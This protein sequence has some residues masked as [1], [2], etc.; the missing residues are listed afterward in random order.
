M[1]DIQDYIEYTIK[2]QESVTEIPP[3]HVYIYRINSRS[4]FKAKDGC[5]LGLQTPETMELLVSA[6]K[7]IEKNKKRRKGT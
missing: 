1:S 5:K 6:K 4:V 2:K 7:L 3:I